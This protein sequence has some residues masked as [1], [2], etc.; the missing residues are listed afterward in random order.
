MITWFK[1]PADGEEFISGSDDSTFFLN[2]LKGMKVSAELAERGHDY[3]MENKVV[4][5][6][7]DGTKGYAVVEGEHTYEVTFTYQDGIVSNLLCDCPCTFPCKHAFA[8]MLQLRETLELI[9]KHYAGEYAQSRYFAAIVKGVLF[10]F[11]ID[12]KETGSFTL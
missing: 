10:T 11:A 8:A 4:Y 1:A 3:Y 7:V 6:S 12:G 5:I 2:D 9:E